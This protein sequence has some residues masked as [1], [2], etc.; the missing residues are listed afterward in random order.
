MLSEGFIRSMRWSPGLR[1]D[2]KN[3]QDQAL[4]IY[5][6]MLKA[7]RPAGELIR[8]ILHNQRGH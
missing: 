6:A 5:R 7:A 4:K 3:N 8:K 1:R 2:F